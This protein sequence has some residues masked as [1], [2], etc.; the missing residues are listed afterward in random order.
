MQLLTSPVEGKKMFY[1][2]CEANV[3]AATDMQIKKQMVKV[4]ELNVDKYLFC[5][6]KMEILQYFQISSMKILKLY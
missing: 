4:Q 1:K 5:V 2:S 3:L 6:K